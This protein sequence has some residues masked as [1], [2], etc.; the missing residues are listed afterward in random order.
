MY[1]EDEME[2]GLSYDAAVQKV[3][4]YS[5][6]PGKSEH[7][8]GLCVDFTTKSIGGVVDDNFETTAVFS[9]L[10]NN[11]WK[12]GFIL[13]YAEDKE[14]ITGYTYE[15]WHYR[16]VGVEKASIIH[17]TGICYEEYLE[18]FENQGE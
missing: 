4:T 16:F 14:E 8:T 3:M 15:S 7:Q 17:Q 6:E 10:K 12:Y 2:S 5:S 13:R 1:V 11:A 18:I 9:W